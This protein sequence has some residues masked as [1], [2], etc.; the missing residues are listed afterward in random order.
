M[1]L[2]FGPMWWLVPILV[3]PFFELWS[4]LELG[5]VVGVWATLAWCLAMMAVGLAVVRLGRTRMV[6]TLR[7]TEAQTMSTWSWRRGSEAGVLLQEGLLVVAGGLFV[8]PGVGSDVLG[9]VLLLPF[10]RRRVVGWVR[11]MSAA[12]VAPRTRPSPDTPV[13]HDVE[14]HPPGSVRLP[15]RRRPVVIDVE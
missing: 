13:A 1:W 5:A 4:L 10:L 14:I 12:R 7:R 9:L 6:A 15:V 8:F 3:L 2:A 11:R